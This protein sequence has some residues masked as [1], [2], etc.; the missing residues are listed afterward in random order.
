MSMER[1]GELTSTFPE[2]TTEEL[3]SRTEGTEG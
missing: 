1:G 3:R 2:G